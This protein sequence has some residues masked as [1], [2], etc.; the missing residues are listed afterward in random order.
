MKKI[1][2]IITS[3]LICVANS[4]QA[5]CNAASDDYEK[6]SW[7]TASTGTNAE[8][9]PAIKEKIN[10]ALSAVPGLKKLQFTEGTA[11]FA[12]GRRSCKYNG[13]T[14]QDS[15]VELSCTLKTRPATIPLYG[16]FIAKT[17]NVPTV[18]G[19]VTLVVDGGAGVTF[20][21]QFSLKGKGGNTKLGCCDS[22]WG[23]GSIEGEINAELAAVAELAGG[24]EK[25]NGEIKYIAN[26]G[27]TLLKGGLDFTAALNWNERD[28]PSGWGGSAKVTSVYAE[29]KFKLVWLEPKVRV[30][31]Y[32]KEEFGG[33]ITCGNYEFTIKSNEL[34]SGYEN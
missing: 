28:K 30:I 6:G 31:F 23:Y 26:V 1:N 10:T 17:I 11:S 27:G 14:G 12:G 22:S 8:I 19:N 33:K 18:L 32:P 3:L 29:S 4:S 15:F 2:L 5:G 24:Y 20:N 9:D 13:T 34:S 25:R 7:Y 16:V 21:T